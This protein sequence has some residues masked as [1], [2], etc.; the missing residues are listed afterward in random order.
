[1]KRK[2]GLLTSIS[3]VV[4]IVIGS[5]VFLKVQDILIHTKGNILMGAMAWVIGGIVMIICA[6]NFANFATKYEKYN[7]IV[8]YAESIVGE[9]YAYLVG[10]FVSIVYFPAMTSVLAWV[11][12]RYTMALFGSSDVTGGMCITVSTLYLICI[13]AINTLAP[14]IAGKLQVSHTII[15]LIPLC[16]M[17]VVGTIIGLVNGNTVEALKN[18]SNSTSRGILGAIVASAFAYEGWIVITSLNRE[19]KDSKRNLPKAL[20]IGCCVVIF[21]YVAYFI[22]VCGSTKIDDLISSGSIIGFYNIFGYS[23]GIILNIFLVISC[24]GTLNGLMLATSRSMYSLAV[25]NKGIAVEVMKQV[26][27]KT[28]VPNNSSAF[29]LLMTSIWLFYFYG[30]NLRESIFGLF[31]FDSSELPIVSIYMMY[32]PIFI[33]FIKVEGR[34]N[35]MKN[36]ILPLLGILACLF[37]IFAAI[38]AHGIV[39]Y[40]E[41]KNNGVF[42]FPFLFYLVFFT[43]IIIIGVFFQKIKD[44]K[45]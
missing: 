27:P 6:L 28:D 9:K 42:S 10:W 21:I 35:I 39:P 20:I 22:G 41:A 29:G 25:R 26:D 33:C 4:G 15:K 5:G 3:V 34:N 44:K 36:I 13:Y 18:V 7:G 45:R 32:I 12:G 24:F 17:A 1:M 11:S 16:V 2:Y 31:S 30:A 8:D 40:L 23:G 43:I 38:Y 37:M 14:K 19:I